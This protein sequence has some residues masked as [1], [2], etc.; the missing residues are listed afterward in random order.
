MRILHVSYHKRHWAS[1]KCKIP[2]IL[3]CLSFR[4]LERWQLRHE[5]A[6]FA[7]KCIEESRDLW[8]AD[9]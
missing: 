6:S 2:Y 1:G 4:H 5:A 3:P 8:Y 7:L 9:E